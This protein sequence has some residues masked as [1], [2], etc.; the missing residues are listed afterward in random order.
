MVYE[1]AGKADLTSLSAFD[2][3]SSDAASRC[4]RPGVRSRRRAAGLMIP[5]ALFLTPG[6][7]SARQSGEVADPGTAGPRLV[8]DISGGGR[9][10]SESLSGQFR[11]DLGR[12]D[13]ATTYR[14][15]IAAHGRFAPLRFGVELVDSRVLR[16]DEGGDF[17]VGDVNAFE[18]VQAYVGFDVGVMKWTLGRFTQDIGSRRLIARSNS[19]NAATAFTGIRSEWEGGDGRTLTALYVLPGIRRPEDREDVFHNHH[20]FDGQTR[21]RRIAGL[22]YT[23]HPLTPDIRADAYLFHFSDVDGKVRATR[24]RRLVV[25]GARIFR[26]PGSQGLDFELEVISQTGKA[27]RTTRPDDVTDLDVVAGAVHAEVGWTLGDVWNSRVE[28]AFDYGSGDGDPG[29]DRHGRFEGVFGTNRSDFGP[30]GLYGALSRSNVIVPTLR[31]DVEPSDRWDAYLSY[32]PLW[33]ARARDVFASTQIRDPSGRSGRFAGHQ[34]E[35]RVRRRLGYGVTWETGGAWLRP[36]GFLTRAPDVTHNGS[37]LYGYTDL[38]FA[39]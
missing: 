16:A 19:G 14:T 37:T 31:L 13:F 2:F 35:G 32:K 1:M 8:I 3:I 36:E 26:E 38:T 12:S 21:D 11:P 25:T 30:G 27:R 24:D 9:I 10:R 5:A 22:F 28:L 29:D 18:P 4:A 20:E 15:A 7:A 33:L 6:L 23:G 17:G 34:I 39:F